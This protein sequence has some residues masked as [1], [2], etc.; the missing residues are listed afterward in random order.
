MLDDLMKKI[1][2]DN[3]RNIVNYFRHESM[4][5]QDVYNW[6]QIKSNWLLGI[7]MVESKEYILGKIR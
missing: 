6:I 5:N 1:F 7:L 3:Y 2:L 4:M